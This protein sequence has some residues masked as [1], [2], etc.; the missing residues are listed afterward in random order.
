MDSFSKT[1]D[2]LI[3]AM[4]RIEKNQVSQQAYPISERLKETLPSQSLPNPRNFRQVNEA[5]DLSQ[6]NVNHTL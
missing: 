1:Q 4:H 5:Q 2:T 6:C 3:Q